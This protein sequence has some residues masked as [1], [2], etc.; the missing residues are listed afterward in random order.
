MMRQ[1]LEMLKTARK[2]LGVHSVATPEILDAYDGDI[3]KASDEEVT[4][5]Q[6]QLIAELS[7]EEMD[8]FSDIWSDIRDTK[9]QSDDAIH[10]DYK[11]AAVAFCWC[12]KDRTRFYC[13][14]ASVWEVVQQLRAMPTSLT[15]RM[16]IVCNGANAFVGIDDETKKNS[17]AVT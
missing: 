13:D 11:R 2:R 14:M 9:L 12:D 6:R 1:P 15:A 7:G 8:E 17:K 4:N 5:M 16:F 10:H 3:E